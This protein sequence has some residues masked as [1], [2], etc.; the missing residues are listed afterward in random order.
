MKLWTRISIVC[1]LLPLGLAGQEHPSLLLSSEGVA[2]IR[3]QAHPPAFADAL[4]DAKAV[5]E[6]AIQK[7]IDVPIPKDMAGGYTHEQHK[8]NYKH[9]SL[10]GALYQITGEERYAEFIKNMLLAYAD[11]YPDLPIHPTDR[12]Y[13][14][15]KVFWQCLNDANW[16]VYTAQA[17]DCIYDY[18]DKK[19]RK[20][21]ETKLF[22]PFAD[23]L[24]TGNPQFFNRVHNHST[25]GN[26]AVGMIGLVMSDDELIERALYGLKLKE[27]DKLAKDNDGGFIYEKGKSKAGFFAQMD[28]A[29]SPDGYYTEGPYYQRYAMTPFMLFA[30]SLH[31]HKPELDIFSYRD[32]LLIKAVNALLYQ[33]DQAGQFFPINDAQ[34]GMSIEALSV[35]SAVNIAYGITGDP[36]LLGA[37]TLQPTVLLDQQGFAVAQGLA[38][39]RAKTFNKPSVQ[40]RDGAE[41]EE[42]ALGIL[43]MDAND[44]EFAVAFKYTAQGLGHGHFDKLSYSFYEGSTEILQ[45]YG[46]AR[47]VNIDQ[48]AGGRYLPENKT[49]AK[50]TLAHNTLIV[51][52]KSHFGGKYKNANTHYSEPAFFTQINEQ[53][54][55]ASAK[56]ENAY[57]GVSMQ[58]SLLFWKAPDL[59][60]PILIDLMTAWSDS[61][62]SY[63]LPWQYSSH[64]LSSSSKLTMQSPP[65]VMGEKHGYQ[66][67]YQEGET[68]L[69]GDPL[70]FSWFKDRKFY[71]LTT[72]AD[73]GDQAILARIGANDPNVNLR[74]DGI[75]VHRK[76]AQ[77]N[78]VFLSIIE[79][80]GDYSPVSEVPTQ[81]YSNI[82]NLE[83]LNHSRDYTIF[84]LTT[85]AGKRYRGMVSS[86][87]ADPNSV[88]TVEVDGEKIQWKGPVSIQPID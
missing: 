50:Q 9:M 83:L 40:L 76:K 79:P 14:T 32:S 2:T 59:P 39:G 68:T 63:E 23:F 28:F 52:Q 55:A 87:D 29:F 16:L 57:P 37:A 27:T 51:D 17:Y 60:K 80:H 69:A 31:H 18:V 4:A 73:E 24:S 74:R 67:V 84:I 10:A 34:K 72:L 53:L 7:G 47:W 56:E 6:V 1:F 15:G 42:G 48:K 30:L 19:D 44:T 71:T 25:W 8:R 21:L 61:E 41:G 77:N 20:K 86:Q 35:V 66:H 45:D 11:M 62:H 85:E 70:Q 64:F 81:P 36:N 78:A 88:H 43:R 38:S 46:A 49:W 33:T 13:S 26:A 65:Q 22:R 75:L 58:R 54:I 12:S 5:V 3:S 82:D